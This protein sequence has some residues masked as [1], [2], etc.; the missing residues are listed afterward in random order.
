MPS[1]RAAFVE[2]VD[3]LLRRD[4]PRFGAGRES[5]FIYHRRSFPQSPKGGGNPQAQFAGGPVD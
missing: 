4:V 2:L 3:G 5:G 1:Q